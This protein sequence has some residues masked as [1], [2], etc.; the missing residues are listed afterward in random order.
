MTF[1]FCFFCLCFNKNILHCFQ[2]LELFISY[3]FY[4][5]LRFI[6]S[7]FS[8]YHILIFFHFILFCCCA[9]MY[10][11]A[12]SAFCNVALNYFSSFT[13]PRTKTKYQ[14]LHIFLTFLFS[15]RFSLL[16]SVASFIDRWN[17]RARKHT[18]LCFMLV[19][20][21]VHR[22]WIAKLHPKTV[23]KGRPAR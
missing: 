5:F 9:V 19:T 10:V 4:M 6:Y 1:L 23:D 13:N 12:C 22:G 18:K 2:L 14:F 7:V 16:I 21:R 20:T 17:T 15:C 11:C 3:K 8:Y